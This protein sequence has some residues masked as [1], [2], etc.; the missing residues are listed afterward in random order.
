[1]VLT[2]NCATASACIEGRGTPLL[3]FK[4]L[5]TMVLW[6]LCPGEN[7]LWGLT[8][9]GDRISNYECKPLRSKQWVGSFAT[10]VVLVFIWSSVRFLDDCVRSV[11]PCLDS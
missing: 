5:S 3:L 6:R 10:N 2:L 8:G 7:F 4:F 11:F 1:M 9:W